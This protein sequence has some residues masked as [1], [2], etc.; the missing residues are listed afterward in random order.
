MKSVARGAAG[1][2]LAVLAVAALSFLGIQMLSIH[3]LIGEVNQDLHRSIARD[4]VEHMVVAWEDPDEVP[5]LHAQL[6]DLMRV[7]PAVDFYLLDPE[8][9]IL[10]AG[11][12]AS[13]VRREAVSLEP[14]ARLSTDPEA[15]ALGDDPRE[16]GVTRPISA[17]PIRV[18]GQLRGYLYVVLGSS[19]Y[20][21]VVDMIRT[22]YALLLG[23]VVLLALLGVGASAAAWRYATIVRR[24]RALGARMDAFRRAR[25]EPG[26]G[27]RR[28]P[29]DELERLEAL[30]GELQERVARQLEA[31]E[32]TDALRRELVAFVSHDLKKSLATVAGLIETLRMPPAPL[33]PAQ[34]EQYLEAAERRL[35]GLS[36]LVEQL[37]ALARL[38]D[39]HIEPSFEAFSATDLARDV[40]QQYQVAAGRAGVRLEVAAAP[41]L[42]R[43]WGEIGLVERVL[44]NLIENALR[45]TPDGGR[46]DVGLEP[47][48]GGVA[49]WVRDTGSGID[50]ADRPHL[51]RP[52]YRGHDTAPDGASAGL[53]LA[54]AR[55]VVEIHGGTLRVESA[56]GEG[57]VFRFE[58]RAAP[59]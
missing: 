38:E 26:A 43:V 29:R 3:Y 30:F 25:G 42:P 53:G 44:V 56:P 24:L 31:L 21:R 23:G 12:P 27:P 9:R 37:F 1:G 10:S 50:A 6:A 15:R 55:R 28:G 58:L 41:D 8:G 20:G 18:A 46:V 36:R 7:N 35:G 32:R 22:R 49:L 34:R 5:D 40:V 4:L 2:G 39:P 52:F 45:H 19:R 17:A 47:R 59:C 57:S 14:I 11:N 48:D 13:V 33:T 51:F 16:P 54:I